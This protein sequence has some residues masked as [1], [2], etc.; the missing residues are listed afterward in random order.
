MPKN[1]LPTCN[2][3][4]TFKFPNVPIPDTLADAALSA[5]TM[6]KLVKLPTLVIL[7]CA[8]VV[9]VPAVFAEVALVATFA[10][11][12]LFATLLKLAKLA[13]ATIPLTLAPSTAYAVPAYTE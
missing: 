1:A 13:L 4:K 7:G 12:A 10:V 6:S 8:A 9:T 5:P 2:V 11:F 3:F